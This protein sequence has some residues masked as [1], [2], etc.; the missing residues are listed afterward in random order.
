MATAESIAVQYITPLVQGD[1]APSILVLLTLAGVPV[2]ALTFATTGLT[3]NYILKNAAPVAITPITLAAITTAWAAGG[4]ILVDNTKFPGVYRLDLPA[5]ACAAFGEVMVGITTTSATDPAF[6]SAEVVAVQSSMG[7]QALPN[8]ITGVS[9][10]TTNILI[11]KDGVP[12]TGLAFNS[13]GIAL[14][15]QLPNSAAVVITPATLAAI[16][17]AWASGGFKEIDSAKFP[18]LY[19]M[20]L[21]A[22]AAAASGLLT[23]G[24]TFTASDPA[25]GE[26]QCTSTDAGLATAVTA[27]GTLQTAVT[28]NT[29]AVN[30][31][32]INVVTDSNTT[33]TDH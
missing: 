30:A 26:I 6:V 10:P 1:A 31:K 7:V 5:A 3:I 15:Y 4:F 29:T 25:V 21:P 11:T 12:V 20:D 13:A 24:A 19:R 33:R 18:G 17:T 14:S 9:T 28:A 32:F 27:M 22:A 16:T 23:V 8:I 2:T